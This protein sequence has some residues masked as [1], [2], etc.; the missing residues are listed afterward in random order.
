MRSFGFCD[1]AFWRSRSRC[2]LKISQFWGSRWHFFD[3]VSLFRPDYFSLSSWATLN[4]FRR[5]LLK[6]TIN[7]LTFVELFL[8]LR[9][10]ILDF[11]RAFFN[12]WPTTL[13]FLNQ[14]LYQNQNRGNPF[15]QLRNSHFT[16]IKIN[17]TITPPQN[18]KTSVSRSK[19]KKKHF[20]HPLPNSIT[21][22]ITINK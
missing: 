15:T 9:A 21:N 10:H 11:S 14:V 18:P 1:R 3:R 12:I 20:P 16:K 19:L 8:L 6:I 17:P 22:S 4:L 13:Y 5:A 2:V 7:L